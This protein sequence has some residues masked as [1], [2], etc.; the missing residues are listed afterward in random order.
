MHVHEMTESRNSRVMVSCSINKLMNT[1]IESYVSGHSNVLIHQSLL[2]AENIVHQFERNEVDFA[3]TFRP[4]QG[5]QLE[6]IP[7]FKSELL[8]GVSKNLLCK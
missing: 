3:I 8:V 1:V 6:W 5:P 7:I 2:P 4:I